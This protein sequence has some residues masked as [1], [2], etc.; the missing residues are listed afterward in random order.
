MRGKGGTPLAAGF[1]LEE[2]R[3]SLHPGTGICPE[4]PVALKINVTTIVTGCPA[5][6]IMLLYHCPFLH[7]DY[8]FTNDTTFSHVWKHHGQQMTGSLTSHNYKEHDGKKRDESCWLHCWNGWWSA[9][10]I[11]CCIGVRLWS[12]QTVANMPVFI[13]S[14]LGVSLSIASPPSCP[15]SHKTGTSTFTCPFF[16]L[17]PFLHLISCSLCISVKHTAVRLSITFLLFFTTLMHYL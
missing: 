15:A 6:T 8:N 11:S 3:R 7:C 12:C 5:E 14:D 17:V 2:W 9:V 4:Y 10:C 16:F 13:L 1:A